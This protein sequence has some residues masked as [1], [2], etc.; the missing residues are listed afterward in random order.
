MT[1]GRNAAQSQTVNTAQNRPC[2]PSRIRG[3]LL[4]AL[5]PYQRDAVT[6]LNGPLL[7]VAGP[8]SGKTRVLTHRLAGLVD[9]GVWPSKLLAVTFTNKAAKEMKERLAGLIGQDEAD[10]A[11]VV[12]FHSMCA[13]ILRIHHEAAGLPR[14]FNI[15]DADDA[16][17][18]AARVLAGS[19][20]AAALEPAELRQEA[21]KLHQAISR[22]K[23]DNRTTDALQ[24]SSNPKD[25]RLGHMLAEYNK[26]L[27]RMGVVDFDDL[28]LLTLHMLQ[29]N[30]EV[31]ATLRQRWS[32][33]SVD[34]FQDTNAVQLELVRHLVSD[35]HNICVVGDADQSIY[36]FR[37]AQP[38]VVDTFTA[39]YPAAKVVILERNYRSTAT[40]CGISSAIISHN[41]ATFRA[42]QEPHQPH[43]EKAKVTGHGSDLAEAKAVVASIERR[44]GPLK[45]H[46]VL[47]R[48]NALTR[49]LEQELTA[50]GIDYDVVG[51]VRF[52]E[53]AE[54]RDAVSW[55]VM[56]TNPN[57]LHAFERSIASPKRGIGPKGVDKIREHALSAGLSALE[58]SAQIASASKGKAAA[59]L[60]DYVNTV[61][62]IRNAAQNE[63]PAAALRVALAESGLVEMVKEK[64]RKEGT[65][66]QENLDE[67]LSMAHSF[68]GTTASAAQSTEEFLEL[69]ALASSEDE[70]DEGPSDKVQILTMHSAKGKEF[71]HVYVIGCEQE[72]LPHIRALNGGPEEIAEERRLFFVATSRARK[73]L[74]LSWTAQ[75]M[76]FGKVEAAVPSEFLADLPSELVDVVDPV[77]Q[78]NSWNSQGMGNRTGTWGSSHSTG[79]KSSWGGRQQSSP[80]PSRQVPTGPV[81]TPPSTFKASS[82]AP[83]ARPSH[84][85]DPALVDVGTR[86]VHDKFGPGVIV[87]TKGKTA[88][89]RFAA[90]GDKN[91]MLTA[92]P[93]TLE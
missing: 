80:R 26:I 24:A 12:T 60:T 69:L 59:A 82:K 75:R 53:R 47:V 8:G 6:T 13:R 81:G 37:G 2:D 17:K 40:I 42:T 58:A 65:H 33:V 3:D 11:W 93:L 9:A 50:W 27:R 64:D 66:R 71:D 48:T 44:G 84:G 56:A 23:N 25:R 73:T 5:D 76:K 30:P 35:H 28:M 21:K 52:V 92:A 55:M 15:L 32:H 63:G 54:I 74:S 90:S 31:A 62:N 19:G 72:T 20:E 41:S 29:R 87:S 7:V 4:D 14:G 38:A 45:E 36:A 43:G 91:L 88:V 77:L 18:V 86:V 79:R 10:R 46:A 83:A 67:L 34:E 1:I 61:H 51:T 68:E 70:G 78:T 57:N 22:A 16:A 89:V 39:T 49:T 85:I